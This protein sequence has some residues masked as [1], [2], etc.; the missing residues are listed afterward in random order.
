VRPVLFAATLFGSAALLFVV[1]PMVGKALL[2]V[3]G[4]APAVWAT[5]LVFFQ[6]AL[7]AGYLYA[8][9]LV[10]L[11]PKGQVIGHLA[12]IVVG[13]LA[14]VFF[15]PDPNWVPDESDYP[16]P[17]LLAYLAAAVG[18]PVFV[19]TTT[20]PL[21]QRWYAV[22]RNPYVLYA[23]SNA[24]SLFGL[25][26]Y[27]FL[28]EPALTL[29]A[30]RTD[31][32]V[33]FVVAATAIVFC[34]ITSVRRRPANSQV[35]ESKEPRPTRRQ[36]WTW[37]ALAALPASLLSGVTTHLTT[38]VAPMPLLWVVPLALYLATFILV[39]AWWPEQARVVMSRATPVFL[40]ALVVTL[41][42]GAT[43]PVTLV[44]G[45]HLAAF[46]AVALQ[47]HGELVARRPA[48]VHL[49]RFYLAVS[50]GGVLGGA[51]NAL[52]APVLFA[53]LGP[54]EYPLA[55][56]MAAL[57]RPGKGWEFR[58]RDAI[59]FGSFLGLTLALVLIVPQ[60]VQPPANPSDPDALPIRLIRSGLMYGL[61]AVFAFGLVRNP[62]R[63]AACIATLLVVGALDTASHGRTLYV[64][65]NFF[66]TLRV[67]RSTD[68][69][70]IRL[71]HGTTQHGQQ[72]PGDP[73]P[74][75]Y[76]H[77][78]GPIGRLLEKL[79]PE[80]RRRVAVVGLGCGAMAA[81]AKP[82]EAWTFFEIDPAVVRIAKDEQFFTYLRD[83]QGQLRIVV[84]DA[85]RR[86]ISEP[87]GSFDLLVLDAFSSDAIPTHLLTDEAFAL[88]QN[89]LAP[90]GILAFHL[91]NR[92]LDLPPL[93]ARL[94][95]RRDP[96]FQGKIDV[97]EP[98]DSQ[99]ADGKM[100][101]TWAVLF[102]D[103]ADLGPSMP[104]VQ[105]Q[106]IRSGDGPVWRDDFSNLLSV[107][108]KSFDD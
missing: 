80:R 98:T 2:P 99:R 76:Y 14:A 79:P 15:R 1:Q 55:V 83:C 51:F 62:I 52:G 87:D 44:A 59:W 40:T 58:R 13:I 102:R 31:W 4:G 86:L 20:A 47:C 84:G 39:F 10:R 82:G 25:L 104:G 64:A 72:R 6:A 42:T 32:I 56:V 65:R 34:G 67:A 89:K 28:V 106:P 37:I 49:T 66:G 57:V 7:L 27:P 85:R 96:P 50:V 100:A 19:L 43:E 90:G 68:G 78:T 30:Q 60:F 26:G 71:V 18:L 5:C 48:A 17:G 35:E 41:A 29:D 53:K 88:Y 81:Y 33:G 21:L 9:R 23:A 12:V 103:P 8:D 97:D 93:V 54:I 92:Y 38:D 74:L 36:T 91:S 16:I 3:A 45:V 105:W 46:V 24:G 63:F 101:S 61:P 69:Q 108:K 94:G 95:M 22:G 75:M 70:F 73:K 77:P 11:S 107:W